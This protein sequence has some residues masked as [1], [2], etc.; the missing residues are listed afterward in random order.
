VTIEPHPDLSRDWIKTALQNCVGGR[1]R[2]AMLLEGRSD[3]FLRDKKTGIHLTGRAKFW[4]EWAQL[5]QRWGAKGG[6]ANA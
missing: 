3:S 6:T 1:V 2:D 4:Q 5:L